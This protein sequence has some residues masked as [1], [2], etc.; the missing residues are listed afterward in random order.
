LQNL[1]LDDILEVLGRGG[2]F[3]HFGTFQ[4]PDGAFGAKRDLVILEMVGVVLKA[5][6]V[7][8]TPAHCRLD[9]MMGAED[10]Q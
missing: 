4:L 8:G 3:V 6:F 5:P 10:A 2:D 7:L 9:V 1:E